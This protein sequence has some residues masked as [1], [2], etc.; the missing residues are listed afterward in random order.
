[1]EENLPKFTLGD[2][3]FAMQSISHLHHGKSCNE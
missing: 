1:M 2:H 3:V